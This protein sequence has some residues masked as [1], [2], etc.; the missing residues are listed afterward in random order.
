MVHGTSCES[1]R[2]IDRELSRETGLG[3]YAVLFSEREFKKQRLGYFLPEL[4]R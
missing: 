1:C 4:D 3:G 2:E